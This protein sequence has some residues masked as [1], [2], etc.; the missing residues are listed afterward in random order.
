MKKL[1]RLLLAVLVLL[2]ILFYTWGGAQGRLDRLVL[3]AE[4][5]KEQGWTNAAA[6]LFD[7]AANANPHSAA[8]METLLK[9]AEMLKNNGQTKEASDIAW[10]VVRKYC[11]A[12]PRDMPSPP[13]KDSSNEISGETWCTAAMSLAML[14][15]SSHIALGTREE[16]QELLRIARTDRSEDVRALAAYEAISLDYMLAWEAKSGKPI[17]E[18]RIAMKPT[19]AKLA[20]QA[21]EFAGK[22]PRSY[23]TPHLLLSAAS[24]RS[25]SGDKN[26]ARALY[27]NIIR[28]YKINPAAEEAKIRLSKLQG[29]K[30][31]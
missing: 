19:A 1:L 20:D 22:Y 30:R 6:I 13:A 24:Y 27:E 26:Q 5:A 25:Q 17:H 16:L 23:W 12:P 29:N 10:Q 28:N 4:L 15:G 7:S 18:R 9:K 14:W 21:M 11:G 3:L 8:A 2:A 31:I